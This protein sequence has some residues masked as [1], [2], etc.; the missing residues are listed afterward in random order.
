MWGSAL[1]LGLQY[2]VN[3]Y[4][5]VWVGCVRGKRSLLIPCSCAAASDEDDNGAFLEHI[6]LTHIATLM[7]LGNGFGH[8]QRVIEECC[9]WHIVLPS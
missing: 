6:P 3:G 4:V 5:V 9:W 7:M 2:L 8:V 1:G